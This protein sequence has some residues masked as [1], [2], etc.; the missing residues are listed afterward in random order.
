M[1]SESATASLTAKRKRL[2]ALLLSGSAILSLAIVQSQTH[3]AESPQAEPLSEDE[4]LELGTLTVGGAPAFGD[5]PPEPG[6]LKAESQDSATKTPLSIRETPQSITVITRDSIEARQARDVNTALELAAGVTSGRSGQGGPFAGRGLSEGENF[7][8]RGQDLN[9]NRDI[10]IDGFAVSSSAFDMGAYER[11]EAVKG[12]ASALYGQGSLGGFINLVPRRPQ[13]EFGASVAVQA[14]S[15]DTFRTEFDF[16]GALTGDERVLGRMTVAVDDSGSFTDGVETETALIAPSLEA[17]IGDRT[18]VSGRMLFQHDRY[19]PS[20]GVPLR[21][22]GNRALAPNIPRSM[23]LGIPSMEKSHGENL[24]ASVRVDHEISDRWL[25]SLFLQAGRQENRRFFDSYAYNYFGLPDGEVSVA[26]DTALIENDNWAGELRVQGRFDAFG[27]E[28]IL[29]FGVEKNRRH[30]T[31]A[32]GYTSL[33][34]VNI[35]DGDFESLGTIPGGAGNQPFDVEDDTISINDAAYAQVILSVTERTKLIAG[36]RYDQSNQRRRGRSN[37]TNDD[38]GKKSDSAHTFR[39]GLT[40]DFTPNITAYGSYAE[41]FNPVDAV[42][43]TGEILDPETGKGFEAGIKTEWFAKRVGATAAIF[44]QE[45]ENQPI[46]DLTDPDFSVSGGQQRTNGIELELTGSPIP[47]LTIGA[48]ATWLDSKYIDPTDPYIGLNPYGSVDRLASLFVSYELQS[49]MLRGFGLGATL[50]SEGKRSASFAGAA[51]QYGN[52]SDEIFLPGY[53][54]F[55][56]DVFYKGLPNWDLSLH[57][58]N[59]TDETYIERFRDVSG[60][61]YFGAPR[62]VLVRAQYRF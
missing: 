19:V 57:V 27:R 60:S 1:V 37:L 29:L 18:R 25:A 49:G 34:T 36:T 33:G 23:F 51:D 45:L 5:S 8:M 31:T 41:S 38:I 14:G 43:K 3:A 55:D 9:P 48:S 15:F 28:H 54:R 59:V 17:R 4:P 6:G 52:G 12:P 24:Y 40:H 7:N 58:R 11:I 39:F 35:Y 50:V 53:E 47:G 44:Q 62:S 56:L 16:T 30:N 42:T 21:V 10:R 20:Q 46:P 26:S 61:N 2:Q 32:F 22:D 13:A